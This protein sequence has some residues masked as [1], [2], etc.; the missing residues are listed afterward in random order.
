MN[1][2]KMIL[3]RAALPAKIRNFVHNRTKPVGLPPRCTTSW[4]CSRGKAW[5]PKRLWLLDWKW[6]TQRSPLSRRDKTGKEPGP[7]T[8][9]RPAY[10]T[11]SGNKN[12]QAITPTVMESTV[13][14][15]NYNDSWKMNAC[16]ESD[17]TNHSR[18]NK[19]ELIGQ[20]CLWWIITEITQKTKGTAAGFW[21]MSLM[22]PLIQAIRVIP[23]LILSLCSTSIATCSNFLKSWHPLMGIKL[24]LD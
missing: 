22:A 7:K 17:R 12:N 23:Q 21:L 15:A 5:N 4:P 18:P 14:I 24:D 13:F 11:N 1:F 6:R 19:A 10:R 8:S 16:A 3:F 9:I 20:K 2:F